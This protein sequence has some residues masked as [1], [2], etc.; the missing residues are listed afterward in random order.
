M[1]REGK[2]QVLG[3]V[4]EQH[5]DR[6]ALF[7]QWKGIDWPIL[8]DSLNLLGVHG[9]PLVYLIDEQGV[10]RSAGPKPEDLPRLLEVRYPSLPS[11]PSP[12]PIA[13]PLDLAKKAPK[14]EGDPASWMTYGDSLFLRGAKGD[15]DR[16]VEAYQEAID[17]GAPPEA[18][19]RLG[20]ALRRRHDSSRRQSGDFQRAVNAWGEALRR[21]PNQYI[22]RR[23]IQQYGPRLDKPY[24]FYDW[25][26]KAREEIERRGETPVGLL[27][28]PRGSEI[29][30]PIST[31][32]VAESTR[33]E[34]DPDERIQRDKAPLVKV[35][36][37]AVPGEVRPGKASRIHIVLRPDPERRA[38]WNNEAGGLIVWLSPP[39]GLQVHRFQLSLPPAPVEISEEPRE[40]DFEALVSKDA[41]GGVLI[42]PAYALY[43]VC[44]GKTGVCKY[45][46][47]DFEIPLRVR[48]ASGS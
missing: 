4:E 8:V 24:A 21:R 36:V 20:V 44:E 42:V 31:L 30:S 11:P 37:A 6:C 28:E 15:L 5:P 48:G 19:F 29:A 43:S 35:D 17:L 13:D 18:W 39:R 16:C 33:K 10:I 46:R 7:M 26:T 34:P 22:W 40:V 2:L 47:Q 32:G 45:L 38:H 12:H 27:V 1:V 41:T 9:V 14:R 25:V 23:R 3:I